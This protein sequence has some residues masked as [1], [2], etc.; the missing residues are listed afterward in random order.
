MAMDE[1]LYHVLGVQPHAK[2]TEVSDGKEREG[3]EGRVA[4]EEETKRIDGRKRNGRSEDEEGTRND[5]RIRSTK[6]TRSHASKR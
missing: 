4:T 1:D 5:A 3:N 2:D 6:R